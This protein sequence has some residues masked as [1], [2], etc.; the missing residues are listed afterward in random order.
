ME[1]EPSNPFDLT[2]VAGPG[3]SVKS[4]MAPGSKRITITAADLFMKS[5]FQDFTRFAGD[6]DI[7]MAADG[8][9]TLPALIE[10]V[11]RQLPDSRKSAFEA[12][13]KS[14][15]QSHLDEI[16]R[17]KANAV[18]G[19]DDS[20]ISMPRLYAEL[21]DQ[22]RH[23]DWSLVSPSNFQSSWP[24]QLWA[25][26]KHYQYIGEQ[27]GA[28]IGYIAPA[29][30]GAALAN[31]KHGRLSI[32]IN[33]DGDMMFGPGI[34]WTAAHHSIPLLYI[35]HNNRSYHQE[36]MQ[37]QVIANRRQR[38]IDR[39]GLACDI[40]NPNIDYGMLARSLGVY[41]QGPIE[42]PRDLGPAIRK[43]LAV[44]KKGEPALIDVVSQGR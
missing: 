29:T 23:E 27:G 20:P 44:V 19:W 35:I 8:Q 6:T 9:A 41:G 28:G 31:R 17:S 18:F 5:N 15:A 21:Y 43:A 24:Q 1:L 37:M 10:E 40:T 33:G 25:A 2:S 22:I 38:G 14:L 7:A 3:G 11:R 13:G 12:R 16:T 42:N 4:S 26:D 32:C 30:L 39:V 36:I 34:L